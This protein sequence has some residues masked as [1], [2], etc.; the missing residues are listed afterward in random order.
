MHT[1]GSA[2]LIS[3]DIAGTYFMENVTEQ[4]GVAY[5]CVGYFGLGSC[6]DP[7]P[8]WKHRLRVSWET[9]F[10]STF[11]LGWRYTGKVWNETASDDPD[12]GDPDPPG[13]VRGQRHRLGRRLQLARP[14]VDPQ[15]HRQHP[16]HLGYQQRARQGP[17]TGC[18]PCRR[19][20]L[21]LLLRLRPAGT[22][23][24]RQP[25]FHLLEQRLWTTTGGPSRDRPFFCAGNETKPYFF[26]YIR[27]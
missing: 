24:A 17:A 8:E 9:N 25:S 10:G 22:L 14:R 13:A 19:S 23:H 6:G 12:L 11:S 5:D 20:Q 2:G 26:T 7:Q 21:D 15:L 3:A 18:G 27:V 4:A 1:L 16:V